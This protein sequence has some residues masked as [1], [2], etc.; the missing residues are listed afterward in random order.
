MSGSVS[1]ERKFASSLS[2]GQSLE[3]LISAPLTAI[4]KAN[5]MMLSGQAQFILDYCF[6][7]EGD[8]YRPVLIKLEYS[9]DDGEESCFYVPL[10]TILPVNNLAVDKV[11][12]DFS[13]DIVSAISHSMPMMSGGNPAKSRVLEKKS[14]IGARIAKSNSKKG[15]SDAEMTVSIRARQIPLTRGITTLIDIYSKNIVT[16]EKEK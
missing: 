15:N 4:S 2:T 1:S 13:V 14:R 8:A 3:A 7:S 10:L 12:V 9:S 6:H 16:G 5:V 11:K